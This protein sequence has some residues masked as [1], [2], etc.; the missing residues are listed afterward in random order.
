MPY[1]GTEWEWIHEQTFVVHQLR[2]SFIR[3]VLSGDQPSWFIQG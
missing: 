2:P 3:Y 1:A